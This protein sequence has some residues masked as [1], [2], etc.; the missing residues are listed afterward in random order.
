MTGLEKTSFLEHIFRFLAKQAAV[1]QRSQ[2]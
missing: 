2:S 1:Q